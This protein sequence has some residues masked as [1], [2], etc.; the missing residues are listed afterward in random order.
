MHRK[1]KPKG[2]TKTT[3]RTGEIFANIDNP[4]NSSPKQTAPA[5]KYK[6]TNSP[7]RHGP[8]IRRVFLR[9]T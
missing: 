9:K 1:G 2:K 5:A 3:L 8:E 4:K 7:R 6:N